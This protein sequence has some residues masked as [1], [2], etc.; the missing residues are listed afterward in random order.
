MF[1]GL[2]LT[3]YHI[4]QIQ[5][6]PMLSSINANIFYREHVI[7]LHSTVSDAVKCSSSTSSSASEPLIGGW[8][9]ARDNQWALWTPQRQQ[10]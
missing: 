2:L 4:I 1:S 6:A 3:L 7:L 9:T 5:C 10:Y 8:K